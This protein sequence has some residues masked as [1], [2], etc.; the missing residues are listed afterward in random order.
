MLLIVAGLIQPLWKL[1]DSDAS[2]HDIV[3][4]V[5]DHRT[6]FL[7][8]LFLNAAAVTLWLVPFASIRERMATRPTA[9]SLFGSASNVL[10]TMLLSGFVPMMVLAYRSPEVTSGRDLYDLSFGLLAL[11]G[12]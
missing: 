2:D 9:A 8:A 7:T 3:T 5:A 1:P 12:L 10:V 11:S 6:G 4:Y